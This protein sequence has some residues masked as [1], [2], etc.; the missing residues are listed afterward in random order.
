MRCWG[1]GGLKA[2][3]TFW[4]SAPDCVAHALGPARIKFP[5]DLRC[6]L[7]TAPAETT[8]IFFGRRG[9]GKTTIRMQVRGPLAC[10]S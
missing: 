10:D 6:I 5:C 8:Y 1:A 7:R 4:L 2:E 9:S 3:G